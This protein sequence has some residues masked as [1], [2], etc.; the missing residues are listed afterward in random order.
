M[1][2]T[3]FLLSLLSGLTICAFRSDK[4][5]GTRISN[6]II[7]ANLYFPDTESG[8]YRATRFDWSG[9]IPSLEY[10]NHTFLGQWFEKYSPDIH[11]AIMGPVEEF[12][13]EGFD[14]VKP[15]EIFL[16]PG[17]GMLVKPDE[18]QYSSF[19]LYA[20]K[21]PG[22][23]K[24]IPKADQVEFIHVLKDASYAYEYKKTVRL[25][26]GKPVLV[27]IH[28]F[29][30]TGKNPIETNVYDH[31]FFMIDKATTGPD[32]RVKFV[33]RADGKFQGPEG[34]TVFGNNQLNFMRELVTG[35]NIYCGGLS[36]VGNTPKDYDFRIENVKT[37]AG[38]H[39]TGDQPLSKLVL[40][41]CPTTVC[42]EPYIH[43]RIDPGQEFNW[44]L[45]YEFYTF[46]KGK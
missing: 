8:Y 5:P 30:N 15:G 33:F 32:L 31:N 29:K 1:K 19:R 28:S 34:I 26:K 16:K 42:P 6:G 9:V 4:F 43:F 46:E 11:D 41:A 38:V 10:K 18:T 22:E 14:Q 7:T 40:W 39:I 12:T 35:E 36:G 3:L 17:V 13:A 21:N 45:T 44:K 37:G 20:I 27:L 25:E 2:R 24:T 23:W